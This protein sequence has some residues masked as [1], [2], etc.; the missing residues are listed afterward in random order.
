MAV[1]QVLVAAWALSRPNRLLDAP[2]A[3][4]PSGAKL[5]VMLPGLGQM[6]PKVDGV[7]RSSRSSK[8]GTYFLRIAFSVIP[9]VRVN[10]ATDHPRFAS[11]VGHSNGRFGKQVGIYR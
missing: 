10:E 3:S 1:S 2:P 6:E 9:G 7:R 8:V 5:R 11:G 4:V